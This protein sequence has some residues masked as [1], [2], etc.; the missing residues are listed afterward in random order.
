MFAFLSFF[1]IFYIALQL[2][3]L[4][5]YRRGTKTTTLSYNSYRYQH[6]QV[7]TFCYFSLKHLKNFH[8]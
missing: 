1:T 5:K 4:L 7:F 2:K 3:E 6:K 8:N